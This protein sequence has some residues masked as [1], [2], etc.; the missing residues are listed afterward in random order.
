MQGEDAV[1]LDARIAMHEATSEGIA[2]GFQAD[3]VALRGDPASQIRALSSVELTIRAG[4][5]IY[6]AEQ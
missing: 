5:V 3:L 6:R 4:K 1:T 2:P